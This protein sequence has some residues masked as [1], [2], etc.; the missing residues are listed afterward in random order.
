MALDGAWALGGDE[1]D[2]L[3]NCVAGLGLEL[4]LRLTEN[5]G[6]DGDQLRSKAEDSLVLV[7][8]CVNN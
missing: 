1:L 3:D 2:G 6:E 5:G 7:L 4:L 8:V